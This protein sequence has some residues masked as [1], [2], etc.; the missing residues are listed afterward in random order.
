MLTQ[1]TVVNELTTAAPLKQW[2]Q[3]RLHDVINHNDHNMNLVMKSSNIRVNHGSSNCT[4][5]IS[6]GCDL[7]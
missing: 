7:L 6:G 3:L 4:S 2:E 5:Q 1:E